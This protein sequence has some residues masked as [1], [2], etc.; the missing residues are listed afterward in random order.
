MA[1]LELGKAEVGD[2]ATYCMY[3]DRKACTVIKVTSKTITLQEDKATRLT[4]PA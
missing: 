4:D 3:T 1:F 2:G